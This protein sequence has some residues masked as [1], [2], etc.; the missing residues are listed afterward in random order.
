MSRVL[1]LVG[2]PSSHKFVLL[3]L[4]NHADRYGQTAYP[5]ISS[6]CAE[7]SLK[8]STV[9]AILEKLERDGWIA[10][11]KPAKHH[12]PT[13]WRLNVG[14]PVP[15]KMPPSECPKT[16]K[17][18]VIE[19]FER[20]CEY[21]KR[22][23][24]DQTGPDGNPW[25]VDRIVPNSKGGQY[26]PAN[27]TL[28]CRACNQKK[29]AKDAPPGTRS[30]A[31]MRPP[32]SGSQLPKTDR[33]NL[34]LRNNPYSVEK[35][36]ESGKES[37]SYQQTDCHSTGLRPPFDSRAYK[38]E[39]SLTVLEPPERA[40][41]RAA[42]GKPEAAPEEIAAMLSVIVAYIPDADAAAAE[43]LLRECRTAGP[44]EVERIC[45]EAQGALARADFQRIQNPLGWLL[46]I[47]P[48]HFRPHLNRA[49][50]MIAGHG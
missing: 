44:V 30:L 28:C 48:G 6:I 4:A 43:R 34:A 25:E 17:V 38:E 11:E 50:E 7:T 15:G 33:Q 5:S 22:Q 1:E 20:L 45:L 47:L 49:R 14:L 41:E 39:P 2:L 35:P 42:C 46:T 40:G 3:S 21:C 32:E 24:G 8:N 26:E 19:A 23:G 36:V 31:S 12:S 16:M 37:A 10:A 18:L 27:V 9:R 29:R 13:V